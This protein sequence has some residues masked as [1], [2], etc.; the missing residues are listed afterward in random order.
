MGFEPTTRGLKVS[1][2]DVHRVLSRLMPRFQGTAAT[3]RVH[4]VR[5]RRIAVAVNGAV[6]RSIQP[7]SLGTPSAG[8]AGIGVVVWNILK[9]PT[10]DPQPSRP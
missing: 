6:T 8:Q 9:V 1:T 7:T 3:H 5:C 10:A 4:S 2:G